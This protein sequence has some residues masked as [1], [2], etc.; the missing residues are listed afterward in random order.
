MQRLKYV[1][2]LNPKDSEARKPAPDTEVSFLLMK[3]VGEY[4][5]LDPSLTKELSDVGNGYT[6]FGEGDFW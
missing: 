3:A 5:G 6:Y 4:G 1:A 2:A